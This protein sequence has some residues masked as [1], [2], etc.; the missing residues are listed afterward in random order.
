MQKKSVQKTLTKAKSLVKKGDREQA[1]KLFSE[2]LSEF[3]NNRAAREGLSS[4]RSESI[5]ASAS[6]PKVVIDNLL[7]LFN[8]KKFSAVVERATVLI[9]KYPE[10]LTIWNLLGVTYSNLG[11]LEEASLAFKKVT[12]LNP[13]YAEGFNNLGVALKKQGQLEKAVNALKTAVLLEPAYAEAQNNLGNVL[14]EQSKFADA[15]VCYDEALRLKPEYSDALKNKAFAAKEQQ[16]LNQ[17]KTNTRRAVLQ[18]HGIAK[19]NGKP[20]TDAKNE[21][22]L[23]IKNFA[24][25]TKTTTSQKE[26]DLVETLSSDPIVAVKDN[27]ISPIECEYLIELARPLMRASGVITKNGYENTDGRTGENC[28]LHYDQD[29]VV[30]SIGRRIAD[31]VGFPI[32]HA[33][34]MQVIHYC[35][36]QEYRRHFDAFDLALPASQGACEFGGQRLVTALVY[37]NTVSKGGGT[38]FDDLEI[39]VSAVAGRMLIFHNTVSDNKS[40]HPLSGHAGMPVLEGEKWAFNLWFRQLDLKTKFDDF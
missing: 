14:I 3:P 7:E 25:V 1:V 9:Q 12:E 10:T 21:L 26:Y 4:M 28:W 17:R 23:Q 22:P 6:P 38:L 13:T 20:S 39:N 18:N 19:K 5:A 32:A 31:I 30:D 37:L 16:A 36:D 29:D 24:T 40:R 2:V 33:E 8:T 34:P 15:I 11:K 27:V 35:I